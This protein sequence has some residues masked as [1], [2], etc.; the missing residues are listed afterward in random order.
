MVA[1]AD[2]HELPPVIPSAIDAQEAVA[3]KL[4]KRYLNLRYETW[5]LPR[6]PSIYLAKRAGDVGY[7]PQ[8]LSAQLF[9]LAADGEDPAASTSPRNAARGGEP[10]V[11]AGPNQRPLAASRAAGVSDM[12]GLAEALEYLA[13]HINHGE[14][15]RSPTF[16][17][18]STNSSA[19]GSARS[20]AQ[21]SPRATTAAASPAPSSRSRGRARSTRQ[22]SSLRPSAWRGSR[23]NFHPFIL[24][25]E[26]DDSGVSGV[27]P[28][29]S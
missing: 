2:Q 4:L 3:L 1:K 8:G 27:R 26:D 16:P 25:G 29:R 17:R 9:V 5:P 23:H 19:S 13:E 10:L 12:K 22:R 20:S 7:F 21:F 24:D 11:S 18:R 28:T 6:P 14:L 15:P